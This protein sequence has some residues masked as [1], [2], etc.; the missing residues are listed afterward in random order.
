[1]AEPDP[2]EVEITAR[3]D[4]LEA[5]T[6]VARQAIRGVGDEAE[7]STRKF[8]LFNDRGL[9]LLSTMLAMRGAIAITSDVLQAFGADTEKVEGFQKALSTA[10]NV[11][12]ATLAVY[13]VAFLLKEIAE[14]KAAIATFLHGIAQAGVIIPIAGFAIGAA[15]AAAA[16]AFILSSIPKAQFGGIVSPRP[17][18]TLV[19]VGEAGRAEAIIPL[20]DRR[21]RGS[22]SSQF[23]D[24]NIYVATDDPDRIM[25]VLG[26]RIQRLKSAGF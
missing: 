9:N 2:V 25:E 24:I 23:G 22:G 7:T 10:L 1:M 5:G 21:G 8:K 26:R 13:R 16:V 18:G 15:A 19:R 12:I 20:S 11:G 4:D 14:H 6:R 17:G 3:T